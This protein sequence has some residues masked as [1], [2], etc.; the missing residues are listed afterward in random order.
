MAYQENQPMPPTPGRRG[1]LFALSPSGL[2]WTV[3]QLK[4]GG[5]LVGFEA[6]YT[7]KEA[8]EA[9]VAATTPTPHTSAICKKCGRVNPMNEKDFL[10]LNGKEC[11]C[12]QIA[13]G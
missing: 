7:Y 5:E 9:W 1:R 8:W 3:N 2:M 10:S 11:K 12:H 13:L 4:E 6:F